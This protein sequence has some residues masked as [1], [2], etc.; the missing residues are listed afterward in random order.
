MNVASI[1][2]KAMSQGLK[3]GFQVSVRLLIEVQ[4][5]HFPFLICHFS[6]AIADSTSGEVV[7]LLRNTNDPSNRTNRGPKWQMKNEKWKMFLSL[8]QVTPP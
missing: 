3:L 2:A 6:F 8:Y 7:G 1:T 4:K 5:K